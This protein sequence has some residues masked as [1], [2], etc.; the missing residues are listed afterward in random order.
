MG[1]GAGNRLL[2]IPFLRIIYDSFRSLVRFNF[3]NLKLLC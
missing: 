2:L 3:Q 1:S